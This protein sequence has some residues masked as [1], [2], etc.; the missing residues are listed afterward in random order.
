MTGRVNNGS[1]AAAAAAVSS[2]PAEWSAASASTE[3]TTS[4]WMCTMR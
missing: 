2:G 4:G 1:G 3:R